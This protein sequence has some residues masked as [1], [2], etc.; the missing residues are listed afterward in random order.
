MVTSH[1]GRVPA[2]VQANRLTRFLAAAL[3]IGATAAEAEL[4]HRDDRPAATLLL[5]YFEVDLSAGGGADTLLSVTN[6]R[7]E[8]VDVRA[9]LWTDLGLPTVGFSFQLRGWQVQP[10]S[11]RAAFA[12]GFVPHGR[13]GILVPPCAA[14]HPLAPE[15][16]AE[17]RRAHRGEPSG[18]FDG[19]CGAQHLG[20]GVFRGYL[21]IDVVGDVCSE[22]LPGDPGYFGDGG[23][24][25]SDNVLRGEYFQVD[26]AREAATSGHLLAL[27]ADPNGFG[28]GDYTFYNRLVGGDGSDG[29]EPLATTWSGRFLNGGAFGSTTELLVWRDPKQPPASFPCGETPEWYPLPADDVLAFDEARP[30][31]PVHLVSEELFPAASNRVGVSSLPDWPPFGWFAAN[32]DVSTGSPLDPFAQGWVG[33]VISAAGRYSVALGAT[34]GDSGCEPSRCA[35]G[36]PR[37]G[38][39]FCLGSSEIPVGGRARFDLFPD[40]PDGG[41]SCLEFPILACSVVDLGGG[42][43]AFD[44]RFCHDPNPDLTAICGIVSPPIV[45]LASCR[46]G[47]LAAGDYR[48]TFLG[49][50]IEFTVPRA[51]GTRICTEP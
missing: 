41:T 25:A 24:A 12:T 37:P 40:V 20:D 13:G 18:L 46:T 16:V 42:E 43:L 4:C 10:I 26:P 15:V 19:A 49:K 28:P 27:E 11:L 17:L 6:V 7:G 23:L 34:P 5:P 33:T 21:T 50:S 51:G 8:P 48:A 36:T 39:F 1:L 35:V 3:L 31:W 22:L 47:G 30:F 14:D 9:V 44:A 45:D 29:R 38:S 2:F 32:L